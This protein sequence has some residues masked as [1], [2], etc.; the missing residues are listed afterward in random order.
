MASQTSHMFEKQI[1]GESNN[2]FRVGLCTCDPGVGSNTHLKQHRHFRLNKFS[3]VLWIALRVRRTLIVLHV[4]AGWLDSYSRIQLNV[5]QRT[6]FSTDGQSAL[7][8]SFRWLQAFFLFF[9]FLRCFRSLYRALGLLKHCSVVFSFKPFD[10][11]IA[12]VMEVYKDQVL[13]PCEK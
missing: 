10:G 7:K 2:T 6:N 9:R 8:S 3:I 1:V 12:L 11:C 5:P 4:W 13:C